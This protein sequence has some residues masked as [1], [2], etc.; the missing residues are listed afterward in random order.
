MIEPKFSKMRETLLLAG[1]EIE[2]TN[3]PA[4]FRLYSALPTDLNLRS[5][6]LLAIR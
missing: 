3:S 1:L 2:L 6:G 4:F 5:I